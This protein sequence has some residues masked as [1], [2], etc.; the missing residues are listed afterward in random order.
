MFVDG[1]DVII[2]KDKRTI[3]DTFFSFNVPFV[4]SGENGCFPLLRLTD[5]YPLSPS[6]TNR[7]INAGG[8]IGYVW[9]LKEW[10]KSINP[11]K[12]LRDQRQIAL[13]YIKDPSKYVIDYYSKIFLCL[14][15]VKMHNVDIDETSK[16]FFYKKTNTYPCVIHANGKTFKILNKFYDVMTSKE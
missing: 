9:Y 12:Y 4:I 1:F 15:Q 10:L 6:G 5:K 14:W 7:Y 8:Y 2:I 11:N 16:T 3:L 13:D